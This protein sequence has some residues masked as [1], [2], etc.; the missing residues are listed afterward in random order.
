M[1]KKRTKSI[2]LIGLSMLLYGYANFFISGSQYFESVRSYF[3]PLLSYL[4]VGAIGYIVAGGMILLLM[5]IGV[6][7][8]VISG[9]VFFINMLPLILYS[10]LGLPYFFQGGYLFVL[11]VSFYIV[12]PFLFIHYLRKPKIKEQLE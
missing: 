6:K 12:P 5:K 9:V 1:G 8:A 10:I 4:W 11:I 2:W 3:N 7:L